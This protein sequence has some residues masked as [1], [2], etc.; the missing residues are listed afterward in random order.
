MDIRLSLAT[1]DTDDDRVP[2]SPGTLFAQTLVPMI[3]KM[4]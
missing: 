3:P 4:R 1:A 2:P